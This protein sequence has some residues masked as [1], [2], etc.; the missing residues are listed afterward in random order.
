M[1]EKTFIRYNLKWPE[2]IHPAKMEMEMIRHNGRWR[3]R[4]GEM[5]GEGELFHFRALIKYLWPWITFHKWIDMF[6][7]AYL[8][9]RT[10]GALGPASSGKTFDAALCVLA[11]WYCFSEC[12]TVICCSTTRERLEDRIWGEI[13]R[14]H[15]DAK[16][17]AEWLPGY[18]IEGRQRILADPKLSASEGRDFRNGL[19]GVAC[20]PG[21]NYI[22]LGDFLGIK[23][24]RVRLVGDELQLL[25]KAFVDSISNLDKNPDL[26]A[27]GLGNPKDILDALGI[28]CEPSVELGGWDSGID[29]TPVTK[30]WATKRA[31]GICLQFPGPDSPNFDGTLGIPLITG[32]QI[33]R[34]VSQYG[35][36]SFHYTSM[37]LG[38]MP[39]G[40][41]ARRVLTRQ[42][43]VKFGALES[44][45][46]RNAERTK[47]GFL[48][49]AYRGVGGDRCIF[50]MLEFG[51]ETPPLDA[52]KIVTNLSSQNVV[53]PKGRKIIALTSIG[54][55]PIKGSHD[56]E[57]QI[58]EHVKLQCEQL[59]IPT[60]NFF[61]DAGMR[62]S[63]TQSFARLWSSQTNTIDCGGPASERKV[64]ADI[65]VICRDY[66]S[67]FITE[68]WFSVRLVVEARQFRG[69]TES[70]MNEFCS[71]EW[72]T[73]G[74]NKIEVETKAKMK[75]KTGRSPDEADAVAIGIHGAV[76]LGFQIMR[77]GN[78]RRR[79][80]DE[81]WKKDLQARAEAISRSHELSYS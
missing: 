2:A 17:N 59:G 73:V 33:A 63:L 40:Q 77:L 58:V 14:L 65:D 55:V 22:G 8:T 78:E 3:A 28:F 4:S 16:K 36:D 48:D 51:E 18:L 32:E 80:T 23:N 81:Q 30:S 1:A 71:R 13:K 37:N 43:C 53:N 68:L 39:K 31:Q 15:K 69:M 57:D 29:Q 6:I 76:N 56:P 44:P 26:K 25:P 5:V 46:W 24:K 19:L 67:K 52:D 61:Y 75:T 50:G 20:K 42:T 49:A 54:L 79:S 35:T 12:T 66:Y 60:Q 27:L 47:V 62:T 45:N 9:H 7:E 64:S 34:D 11:D 38:A 10:I 72:T 74:A 41:G 21:D 70:V